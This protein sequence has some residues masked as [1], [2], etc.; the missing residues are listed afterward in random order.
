MFSPK[1]HLNVRLERKGQGTGQ[2]HD[3]L[4]EQSRRAQTVGSGKSWTPQSDESDLV[5]KGEVNSGEGSS[6]ALP[7]AVHHEWVQDTATAGGTRRSSFSS[8]TSSRA[9]YA[10]PLGFP[11]SSGVEAGSEK[12]RDVLRQ[13]VRESLKSHMDAETML[14]DQESSGDVLP[15]FPLRSFFCTDF[16]V[17]FSQ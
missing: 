12:L 11:S 14:S 8:Q 9:M 3:V 16:A 6:F 7:G 13:M 2:S 10:R 17:Q 15:S 4:T 1:P 5:A